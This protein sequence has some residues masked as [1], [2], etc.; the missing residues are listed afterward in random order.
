VIKLNDH[1]TKY[2]TETRAA[3]VKPCVKLDG[4]KKGTRCL[5]ALKDCNA[6]ET[7]AL[8]PERL[9]EMLE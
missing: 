5:S 7:K 8:Q 3:F 9:L 6:C 2:W 1:S 4:R